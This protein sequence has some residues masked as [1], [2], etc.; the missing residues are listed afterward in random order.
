MTY[1]NRIAH[2][3]EAGIR[4]DIYSIL[5]RLNKV[6]KAGDGKWSACCPAHADKSPSLSIRETEDGSILMHCF[7]GC[8][9]DAVTGAIGMDVS[10]LFPTIENGTHAVKPTKE[11]ISLNSLISFLRND[12]NLVVCAARMVKNGDKLSDS[13]FK[14]LGRS[15]DR[16]H[17]GLNAAGFA[18][19]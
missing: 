1:Q 2:R 12:L 19:V 4:P 3:G 13:D 8:S 18:H 7:G 17:D 9:I 16:I 5:N 15:I 14:A 6:R 10:D 11:R